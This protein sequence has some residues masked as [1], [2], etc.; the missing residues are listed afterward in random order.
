M[1]YGIL[2]GTALILACLSAYFDWTKN[3]IPNWLT[4]PS[5]LIGLSGNFIFFGISGL[6]NSFLGLLLGFLLFLLFA[7]R[8]IGAGDVKLYMA[9]GALLGPKI[10]LQIIIDSILVGGVFGIVLIW[11]HKNGRERFQRLWLYLQRIFLT[12]NLEAYEIGEKEGHFCFGV[13][14]SLATLFVLAQQIKN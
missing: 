13:C 3:K 12:R 11:I 2:Y 10:N 8:M 7:V 5:M 6:K 4:M 14:I 1:K 9:L